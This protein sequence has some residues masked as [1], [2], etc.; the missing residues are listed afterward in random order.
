MPIGIVDRNAFL[1]MG[2][3]PCWT[4]RREFKRTHDEDIADCDCVLCG[5]VGNLILTVDGNLALHLDIPEGSHRVCAR[6]MRYGLEQIKV[7]TI[8]DGQGGLESDGSG[9]VVRDGVAV[10]EKY[11]YLLKG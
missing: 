2:A 8:T 7:L 6:C 5:G 9:N 4:P 11:S 10:P 3:D 1:F